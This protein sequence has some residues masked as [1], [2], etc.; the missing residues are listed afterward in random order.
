V[1]LNAFV[2]V[3]TPQGD[4]SVNCAKAFDAEPNKDL[5]HDI[6]IS[7]VATQQ[8][9][10][11]TDTAE[12]DANECQGIVSEMVP[13]HRPPE[14]TADNVNKVAAQ[15]LMVRVTGQ[16]FFDSSHVPC[17]QGNEVR[18]NPRRISL[19]EIHPIYKFEVCTANCNATG[20]WVG[21]AQWVTNPSGSPSG[22][23]H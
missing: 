15:H 6:H 7:L 9:A 2:V 18:K 4:E 5:F 14:W 19:W 16:L 12:R 22:P 21:L 20:T 23:T 1:Q 13:H 17:A 11:P 8:L 3:A 10:T